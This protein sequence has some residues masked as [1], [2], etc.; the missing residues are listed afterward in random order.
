M[1]LIEKLK[2]F[3]NTKCGLTETIDDVP[4]CTMMTRLGGCIIVSEQD[5]HFQSCSILVSLLT[6]T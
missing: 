4:M 5:K 6:F 1:S 3:I 2:C